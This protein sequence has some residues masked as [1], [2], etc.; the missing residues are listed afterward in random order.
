MN[1][2]E[3]LLKEQP[4]EKL[5]YKKTSV[6]DLQLYIVKPNNLSDGKVRTAIIW[7][8]GGGWIS[9]DPKI[10][11]P[12][13]NYFALKGAVSFSVEYRLCDEK[14]GITLYDC[15][16]DCR[17]AVAFIRKNAGFFG[18]N[19]NKI[20][21]LGDSAGGHLAACLLNIKNNKE[22]DAIVN[23]VVCYNPILD[24]TTSWK[25]MTPGYNKETE[26]K[27]MEDW[28]KTYEK[29]KELSP[30]YAIR[31]GNAPIL[32]MHGMSDIVVDTEQSVRYYNK[33]KEF[34]NKA[35]LIL[36]PHT[37]HAFV[38]IGFNEKPENTYKVLEQT[39]GFL[40]RLD[41]LK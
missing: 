40:K 22:N 18:I 39:E 2:W 3:L 15:I 25:R 4:F 9:G 38:V 11:L 19:P 29:A 23:A 36:L 6:G 35:E 31:E 1:K 37:N 10:F 7:I 17:D 24:L 12:N 8:H 14:K 28:L 26:E 13:C 33:T 21:V 30:F 5:A 32:I 20:V 34:G 41:F 27:S 16:D